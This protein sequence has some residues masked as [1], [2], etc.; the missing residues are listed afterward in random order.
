[1]LIRPA[2]TERVHNLQIA[3][4]LTLGYN[5]SLSL[6]SSCFCPMS[7]PSAESAAPN[8][9]WDIT[10]YVIVAVAAGLLI[11]YYGFYAPTV[12]VSREHTGKT[13]GTDYIVQVAQFPERGDWQK[14]TNPP[15]NPIQSNRR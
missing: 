15:A 7:E 2:A 3:A 14:I 13:M 8:I 5:Y 6:Y 1:M 12:Y 9:L 4:L 10:R 11:Y